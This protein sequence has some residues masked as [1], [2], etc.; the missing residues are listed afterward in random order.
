MASVRRWQRSPMTGSAATSAACRAWRR[1]CTPTS[2]SP[3]PDRPA[4]GGGPRPD[5]PR[6][7]G[8]QGQAASAFT[9]AW[10]QQALTAAAL[11]EYVTALAQVIDGLAVRLSQLENALEQEA[12]DVAAHGVQVGATAASPGTAAAGPGVRESL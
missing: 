5:Q 2:R 6:A 10:Q 1:P 8:W 4:V 3:G 12:A 9:A 7:G 11:Q